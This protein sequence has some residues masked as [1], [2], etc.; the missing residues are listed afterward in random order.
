MTETI[1]S[2]ADAVTAHF[3]VT[4]FRAGTYTGLA[5]AASGVTP[6]QNNLGLF[7]GTLTATGSF[8]G[9]VNFAGTSTLFTATFDAH[10]GDAARTIGAFS[11]DLHLDLDDPGTD[12]ITGT[13]VTAG[14]ECDVDADRCVFSV[15]NKTPDEFLKAGDNTKNGI[16]TVVFPALP[17]QD[18]LTSNDYPQGDGIGTLT[19]TPLGVVSL[20]G[21]LADGT[22]VTASA[23]M[24]KIFAWPMV[25][26]IKS[27]TTITGMTL[28]GM[29]QF[30]TT[31]ADSDVAAVD[32]QWFRPARAGAPSYP[33]GWPAGI[34]TYLTGAKFATLAS[35]SELPGLDTPNPAGNAVLEFQGGLLTSTITKYLNISSTNIV[36]KIPTTDTSY[37]LSLSATTGAFSGTFTP[38]WASPALVKPTFKGI[39]IQKGDN[40][41]GYGFFLS[42]STGGTGAESGNVTLSAP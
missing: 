4:P 12:K 22:T 24:S 29:V 3:M 28:G 37:T 7:S 8:S 38:N 25:V 13:V 5:N 42:N 26:I 34:S 1:A 21:A 23:K 32:L 40:Q 18:G 36:T 9:R 17:S 33:S 35:S 41:G 6:S 19:V 27:T 39:L 31:P 15:T 10:S 16:Y 2:T 11:Y 20:A 14:G 30:D